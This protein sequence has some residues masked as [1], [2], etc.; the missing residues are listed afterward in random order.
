MNLFVAVIIE[1]FVLADTLEHLQRPGKL[2]SVHNMLKRAYGALAGY[3]RALNASTPRLDAS[4]HLAQAGPQAARA[5]QGPG[6]QRNHGTLEYELS[7]HGVQRAVERKIAALRAD[8]PASERLR[9]TVD[10]LEACAFASGLGAADG[11][12]A[13]AGDAGGPVRRLGSAE[14]PPDIVLGVF[15]TDSAVRRGFVW[16]GQQLWFDAIVY[17][18]I[19]A[20]CVIIVL[21][22]IYEDIPDQ[23]SVLTISDADLCNVVFTVVLLVELFCRVMAHGLYFTPHGYLKSGWNQLDFAILVISVLDVARVIDS[24]SA[25]AVRLVRALSPLR[26]VKRNVG[27]KNVID[28]LV[29]T[30]YPVVY[31][32]LFIVPTFFS[33]ALIGKGVFGGTFFLC[34]GPGAEFPAGKL[35]CC[36]TFA[37]AASGVLRPRA[38]EAPPHNFDDMWSSWVTLF[39]C[40]TGKFLGPMHAAIDVTAQHASPAAWASGENGLFFVFFV[41]VANLFVMNLFIGF[42]VDGFNANQGKSAADKKY[43]RFVRQMTQLR[44]HVDSAQGLQNSISRTIHKIVNRRE[45]QVL[46]ALG[47][48]TNAGFMLADHADASPEFVAVLD[49]QN[50][51]FTLMISVEV[52]LQL[53]AYGPRA[54]AKDAWA[55]LDV[56][57]LLGLLV[58]YVLDGARVGQFVKGLRLLRVLKLAAIIRP[59]RTVLETVLQTLPQMA[60]IMAVLFI[61]LF[62]F[63]CLAMQLFST[64]K[65]GRRLGPTA[66][67]ETWP[68]AMGTIYM[69]IFG[70][71]WQ[72][73]CSNQPRR[74]G[75]GL[76]APRG[77]GAP[78]LR[79]R[80][81]GHPTVILGGRQDMMDDAAVLEPLCTR[82]F[83]GRSFG[84]CGIGRYA[85][86][87]FIV[88]KLVCENVRAP[89]RGPAQNPGPT[90]PHLGPPPRSEPPAPLLLPSLALLTLRRPRGQIML[91]LLIGMILDNFSYV[92][93]EVAP[94]PR[95]CRHDP[96]ASAT[97][98][99]DG[100][101][102]L[103]LL[104]RLSNP[105]TSATVADARALSPLPRWR[106]RRMRSGPRAPPTPKSRA[107]SP[108]SADSTRARPLPPVRA[109]DAPRPG[110]SREASREAGPLSLRAA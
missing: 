79:F 3:Q 67:F 39:R 73:G 93:D 6:R 41:V 110:P 60:N 65:Y 51:G 77:A 38:W 104:R 7:G 72:V 101:H 78:P 105:A 80:S 12:G 33:F 32:L 83:P 108:S 53:A 18:S 54:V 58:G 95:A 28:A 8:P 68:N 35:E 55:V 92:T 74:R 21:T 69:I 85:A 91:N 86:V 36:G 84:D 57:V 31:I 49:A 20:S 15:A 89:P 30:I 1:H 107:S 19:I 62:I 2:A 10:V 109:A 48:A 75:G 94:R 61:Q 96:A 11:A 40:S 5:A 34:S 66:N 103:L 17:T 56:A 14:E 98:A 23:H 52:L 99:F 63:A 29:G 37:E 46:S 81:V 87:F 97:V 82:Q 43:T 16:L 9:A 13:G 102:A 76:Y 44:M 106:T 45:F 90:P 25:R 4:G 64:T 24:S 70:D 47:V 59:V 100:C 50:L 22:P 27:L 26:A 88:L 71:E 42:I